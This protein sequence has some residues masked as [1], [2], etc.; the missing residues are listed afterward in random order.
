MS[1]YFDMNCP[2][3]GKLNFFDAGDPNDCSGMDIDAGECFKCKHRWILSP[4]IDPDLTVETAQNL[5]RGR[6]RIG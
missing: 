4:E 3:C 6:A 2:Q 1:I 5:T